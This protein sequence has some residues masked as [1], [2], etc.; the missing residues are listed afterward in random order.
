M[1]SVSTSAYER[2]SPFCRRPRPNEPSRK[3]RVTSAIEPAI[4]GRST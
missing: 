4:S 3:P 2:T 1:P